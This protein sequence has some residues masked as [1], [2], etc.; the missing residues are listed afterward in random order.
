[1]LLVSFKS[2]YLFSILQVCTLNFKKIIYLSKIFFELVLPS[3]VS[4]GSS[5]DSGTL[6]N[7]SAQITFPSTYVAS[8]PNNV[9]YTIY[10]QE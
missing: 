7:L 9:Q 3:N 5:L 4:S 1:M 6:S 8:F 2:V 10:T